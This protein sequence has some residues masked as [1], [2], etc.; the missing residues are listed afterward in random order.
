MFEGNCEQPPAPI[1]FDDNAIDEELWQ[2]FAHPQVEEWRNSQPIYAP[3]GCTQ[4]WDTPSPNLEETMPVPQE[5]LHSQ[6]RYD[7]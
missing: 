1:I 5:W 3:E 7:R 2:N 4:G 6:A